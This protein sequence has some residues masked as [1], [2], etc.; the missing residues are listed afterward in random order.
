MLIEYQ[1]DIDNYQVRE[2]AEKLEEERMARGE[3]PSTREPQWRPGVA[4]E[5]KQ[6][7]NEHNFHKGVD[8]FAAPDKVRF[9]SFGWY[10]WSSFEGNSKAAVDVANLG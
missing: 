4:Y 9:G 7:A 5:G 6:L 10:D 3:E 2:R 8:V 1:Y